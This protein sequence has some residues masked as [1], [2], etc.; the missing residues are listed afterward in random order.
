MEGFEAIVSTRKDLIDQ[1]IIQ[2]VA[3]KTFSDSKIAKV[4]VNFWIEALDSDS[5]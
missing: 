4:E 3:E 5:V 2:L 1:E